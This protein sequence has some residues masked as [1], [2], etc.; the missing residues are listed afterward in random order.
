MHSI[1]IYLTYIILI[2]KILSWSFG[3]KYPCISILNPQHIVRNKLNWIF[4]I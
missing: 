2:K 3:I 4:L 1:T